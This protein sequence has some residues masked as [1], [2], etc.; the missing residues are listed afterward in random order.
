VK[1]GYWSG[2]PPPFGY[3]RKK[4]L[5]KEGHQRKGA[6]VERGTLVPNAMA[7]I[8]KRAFEI[9][10]ETGKGGR[11]VYKQRVAETGGPVLGPKGKPLGGGGTNAILRN[12][13][14]KGT[15]VYNNYGYKTIMNDLG[16]NGGVAKHKRYSK[17]KEQWIVQ[18]N[19]EWRI[20][21]DELW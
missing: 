4:I 8:V 6:V 3:D 17:P 2:G 10:V 12:P 16:V 13:I 18:Q 20:V 5:N 19:E 15:F 14:Y 11:L 1:A 21:S 9:A 7:A